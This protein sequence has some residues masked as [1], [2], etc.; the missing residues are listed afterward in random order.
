MNSKALQ[1]TAV[2]LAASG[3]VLAWVAFQGARQPEPP[4]PAEARDS[5]SEPEH[6]AVVATQRLKAGEPIPASAVHREP[7]A[8]D[9]EGG[10]EDPAAVTGRRPSRP[11]TVG[12]PVTEHHFLA[13][14]PLAEAIPPDK[15]AVAI[16]V[17]KVSGVG[18][19]IQPGDRVDLLLYLRAGSEVKA[20]Q[21]QILLEGMRV[22]AY[23]DQVGAGPPD[24]RSSRSDQ[25]AAT[26]VLAVPKEDLPALMVAAGSGTMRLALHG[27]QP[28]KPGGS[29]ETAEAS[30]TVLVRLAGHEG[31]TLPGLSRGPSLPVK[32]SPAGPLKQRILPQ[33]VIHRGQDTQTWTP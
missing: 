15:R 31:A 19:L 11:V 28:G 14:G 9:P 21:G 24:A 17:D 2:A 4:S 13:G 32:T 26:A 3:A 16:A 33:T 8:V 27:G 22:L 7:V 30:R 1:W 29:G 12:Q 18:G 25:E 5:R 23:G 6:R 20:T 10:F